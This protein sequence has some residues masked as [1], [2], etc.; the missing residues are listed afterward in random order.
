M[1]TRRSSTMACMYAGWQLM[2]HTNKMTIEDVADTIWVDPK[3]MLPVEIAETKEFQEKMLGAMVTASDGATGR[4][5]RVSLGEYIIACREKENFVRGC[6]VREVD[7]ILQNFGVKYYEN[8]KKP[9]LA[10]WTKSP[11][12]QSILYG[13]RQGLREMASSLPDYEKDATLRFNGVNKR[14]FTFSLDTTDFE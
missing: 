4:P 12:L 2:L 7:E 9:S 8:N 6:P 11:H 13:Y 14:C 3:R 10:V 5:K 1:D